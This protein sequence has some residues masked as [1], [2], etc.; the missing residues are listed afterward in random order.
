[1]ILTAAILLQVTNARAQD[2]VRVVVFPF[3]VHALEELGDLQEQL[4]SLIAG[5]LRDEGVAIVEPSEFLAGFPSKAGLDRLRAVGRDSGADFVVWG[6]FT[7]LGNRY[8][9]DANVM[10]SHGAGPPERIFAE[11]EGMENLLNSVQALARDVGVKVFKREMVAE[12][13]ISGNHRIESEA[14]K[15][16]V[17][18]QP[19][20]LYH[21][22]QMQEDLKSIYKMGYFSDVRVDTSAAPKG[23][24][25]T[26]QVVE[27]Q[28]VRNV[29]LDGN[30]EFN[31]EDLGELITVRSGSILN[32]NRLKTDAH[33]M[34][35]K[36]RQ[37]GYHHV[38]I[39]FEIEPVEENR[40]DIGFKIEEGEKAA[41]RAISFIGNEAY[42][43]KTLGNLMKTREKGFLSWFTS[44]GDLDPEVLD[45]DMSR[46][47]AYYHN[48]GYIHARVA[49]P[50]ITYDGKWIDI[51]IKIDE[52][53]QFKVGRI[54]I[55][56]DLILPKDTLLQEIKMTTQEVYNREV[57]REDVLTLQ[58]V[59]S[60]QGY[61]YAEIS[62]RIDQDPEA[63][64]ANIT[65]LVNKGPV[66]Y[67]EKIIISGNTKTR[68]KVIRRELKVYE[69]EPFSGERLKRGTRNLHRLDFFSDIKVNTI[70]GSADDKMVLK[71]DVTEKPTGAFSFGAGYSSADSL[72]AMASISQRNLFG[73]AQMLNLRA[74][75]G[76]RSTSYVLGFTEP[77]LFDIPLS[78]G[79]DLYSTNNDYN[80]YDKD[81]TGGTVRFGYKIFDYTRVGLSYNY[82]H[83]KIKNLEDDASSAIRE[84]EGTN[85]AHTVTA[86]VRRDSRDQIFSPTEGSDNAFYIKHAGTPFG[87]NIGYTKYVLDSGWYVPLVWD[88]VGLLHGRIGYITDD[89]VGRMPTW[90]RFYLGGIDSMRGYGWRDVSPKDPETGDEIGGNKML[91]FN[92]EIMFPIVKNAGLMGLTFY[93]TGNAFDNG[94]DLNM[95]DLRKSA[96]F[97]FRWYSPMGPM[98]LEYGYVLETDDRG[99]GERGDSRWEFSMGMAF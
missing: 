88:F 44:A 66:V 68:D 29:K 90:E 67:F 49:E 21:V 7:K 23:I 94:E 87:G 99:D 18:T 64:T 1:M 51:E 34:E 54:E 70:K 17:K 13:L 15:R 45:Q 50:E 61:A 42:D 35:N 73:R 47:A 14:I 11:G 37:K 43:G 56:G 83:S 40:A 72:F 69:Q 76:G 86:S 65:Y 80:T 79:F 36:Y 31:D 12:V 95:T 98:R 2:A 74:Q 62:P 59:Y 60:D 91:Q 3:E 92:F 46:I 77:W 8:S 97:G 53:P 71:V 33:Q 28:T 84:F 82:D 93:D 85:R 75:L 26:F 89:E 78:A 16:V 52:G 19:G 9:L 24:I 48:H 22:K 39:T 58:D 57:L 32:I 38:K 30:K 27:N 41:I 5:Q 20:D 96:G 63:L 10:A 55:E 81:S 4:R 25:V 6:S